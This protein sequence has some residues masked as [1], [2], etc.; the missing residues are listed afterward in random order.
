M[1][2]R[3]GERDGGDDANGVALGGCAGRCLSKRL[4]KLDPRFGTLSD[5]SGDDATEECASSD[6]AAGSDGLVGA[7]GVES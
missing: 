2:S 6:A 3:C 4:A 5:G 1:T 7:S